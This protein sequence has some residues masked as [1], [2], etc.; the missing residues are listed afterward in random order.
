V[1]YW[2]TLE[3]EEL[4]LD[5]TEKRD[6]SYAARVAGA[7]EARKVTVLH[8]RGGVSVL[9]VGD[10]IVEA[11]TQDGK[12]CSGS[13]HARVRVQSEREPR[14]ARGQAAPSS[15][16]GRVRAPLPGRIV[17]VFVEVGTR[18]SRGMPLLVIEA[19]KMENELRAETDGSVRALN[20][21]A[22]AAVDRG[23]LLLEIDF[24]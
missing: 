16:S 22:G 6:G 17:R 8:E 7:P 10:R 3:G 13:A 2:V 11:A 15:S 5:V 9:A 18:I 19:M 20:V 1:R 23:T 21:A 24:E 14:Q 4:E 12:V